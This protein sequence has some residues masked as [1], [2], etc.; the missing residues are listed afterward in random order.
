MLKK[1]FAVLAALL[2]AFLVVVA[3]RAP[4]FRYERSISIA[5]PPAAI[6]EHVDDLERWQAWSPWEKLDPAMQRTY[7][8]TTRGVG[9]T[10]TW[11]GNSDVGKGAMTIVESSA[12]ER[13]AM[14]LEFMEP[15][16]ASNQ[17]VFTFV[18]SGD[19]TT[20]TWVMSGS[21]NFVAKAFDLLFDIE[22]MVGKDFEKGLASLKE[23]VEKGG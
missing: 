12:D 11:E 4:D 16:A 8:E 20:V 9:A 14:Q 19:A 5:A 17:V 6:F 1:I 22:S 21:N 10:Y 23:L 15:M 7:S 3:T 18:P 13:I 2:V